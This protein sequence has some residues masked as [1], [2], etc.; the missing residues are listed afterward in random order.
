MA[1]VLVIN[2]AQL[3]TI[4]VR[5]AID[6]EDFAHEWK[7]SPSKLGKYIAFDTV[8]IVNTSKNWTANLKEK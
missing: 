3:I 5:Y 6:Y 2:I 1:L 7:D 4:S 8:F